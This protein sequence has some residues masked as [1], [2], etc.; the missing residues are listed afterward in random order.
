M[1]NLDK[2]PHCLC[3]SPSEYYCEELQIVQLGYHNFQTVKPVYSYWRKQN[4][5]TLHFILNGEGT[6]KIQGKTYRLKKNFC[7]FIPPDVPFLYFPSTQNPWSYMWFGVKGDFFKKLFD[8]YN[9]N[10]PIQEIQPNLNL[11]NL[12]INFFSDNAFLQKTEEEMLAFFFSFISFLKKQP[13]VAKNNDAYVKHAKTL[14][15][16]NYNVC[17]FSIEQIS[18]SLHLSHSRLCDIFKR[19]TDTTLK[20]YLM[21]TRLKFAK[22]LLEE[23]DETIT[24]ISELCG[25]NCP[26]YF[27]NAFKSAFNVSPK[28]YREQFKAKNNRL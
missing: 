16:L 24:R 28:I 3:L 1:L 6:L 5:Y 15:E 12:I 8:T 25:Y 4:F 2:I 9:L 14:I 27:S 20:N 18:E 10:P 19:K 22:R 11:E 21:Q 26:L 23:S 7:F 17:D 13:S